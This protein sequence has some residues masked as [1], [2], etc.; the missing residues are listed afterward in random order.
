MTVQQ[1]RLRT[2]EGHDFDPPLIVLTE[3][4]PEVPVGGLLIVDDGRSF[5]WDVR[6]GQWR[7]PA[8]VAD[9]TAQD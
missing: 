3:E 4:T 7:E 8:F 6:S 2:S 1:F 5:V 9:S